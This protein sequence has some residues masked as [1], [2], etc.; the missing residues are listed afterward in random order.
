M[1]SYAAK[2]NFHYSLAKPRFQ[3]HFEDISATMISEKRIWWLI[4]VS[5]TYLNQHGGQKISLVNFL[6]YTCPLSEPVN[7]LILAVSVA[8]H[9]FEEVIDIHSLGRLKTVFSISVA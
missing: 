4:I 1:F 5:L 3:L 8:I 6:H 7:F 2:P 9:F